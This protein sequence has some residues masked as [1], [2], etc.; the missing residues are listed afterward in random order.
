MTRRTQQPLPFSCSEDLLISGKSA[1]SRTK[2]HTAPIFI[3]D[4][5][6]HSGSRGSKSAEVG[7]Y[8]LANTTLEFRR[9]KEGVALAFYKP[10]ALLTEAEKKSTKGAKYL[11]DFNA[12]MYNCVIRNFTHA[13]ER[14]VGVDLGGELHL[15]RPFCLS[16][17]LDS[18]AADQTLG[19]KKGGT[20]DKPCRLCN[21]P[22][23]RFRD[24]GQCFT[25]RTATATLAMKDDPAQLQENSVHPYDYPV[26]TAPPSF[27]GGR[28]P[29]WS[30]PA[31]KLHL[32]DVGM[33]KKTFE[34]TLEHIQKEGTVSRLHTLN[35]HASKLNQYMW[36]MD[37]RGVVV[38][39]VRSRGI[40]R[41][42]R[43]P[44]VEYY[45]LIVY[46]LFSIGTSRT[47]IQSD[48]MRNKILT[49]LQGLLCFA[50]LMRKPSF[51][52]QELVEARGKARKFQRLW[53]VAFEKL[54]KSGC[55]F[56]KFG[57]WWV[58]GLRINV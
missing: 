31:E 55:A 22:K 18:P 3:F 33:A 23:G 4:D 39:K 58:M 48:S 45:C 26:L 24:V 57:E 43:L 7:L 9:S 25:R 20:T 2:E 13:A 11:A 14:G 54:S 52:P 41:T 47:V 6:S 30:F 27:F 38:W 10:E 17:L 8:A 28:D 42:S 50:N 29:F 16:F 21:K 12:E 40:L 36:G 37:Q 53:K 34:L 1:T 35:Y 15:F 49:A 32:M 19:I 56:K 46:L 44:G 51:T 5:R